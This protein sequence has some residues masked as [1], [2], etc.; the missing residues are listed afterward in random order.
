[1]PAAGGP[2]TL[3]RQSSNLNLAHALFPAGGSLAACASGS[4]DDEHAE[5]A[6]RLVLNG[7]GGIQI[8]LG[9]EA[10]GDWY[11]WTA[12]GKPADQWKQCYTRVALAMK[13]AAQVLKSDLTFCWSMGK[14][15]AHR[16]HDHLSRR[17][18][19]LRDLPVAL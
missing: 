16:R 13:A 15:G 8:R 19:D 7:L 11:P 2:R 18:A 14:K 3:Y 10:N 17:C 6:R 9:W 1:M 12:V 4:Y 5:V